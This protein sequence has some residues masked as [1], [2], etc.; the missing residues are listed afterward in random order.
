MRLLYQYVNNKF[1]INLLAN[2][3]YLHYD[4]QTCKKLSFLR[5]HKSQKLLKIKHMMNS[6]FYEFIK[7]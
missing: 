2:N 3:F 4:E 6:I 5:S 7:R 1:R